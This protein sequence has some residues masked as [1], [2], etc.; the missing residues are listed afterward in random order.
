MVKEKLKVDASIAFISSHD[1]GSPAARRVHLPQKGAVQEG[2]KA[3]TVEQFVSQTLP[4]LELERD[5]EI[6]QVRCRTSLSGFAQADALTKFT[7]SCRAGRMSCAEA[8]ATSDVSNS[9]ANPKALTAC[10]P[11]TA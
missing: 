10:R 8:F 4:L 6:A 1:G 7:L 9:I 5:A 3:L 2:Y 11:R